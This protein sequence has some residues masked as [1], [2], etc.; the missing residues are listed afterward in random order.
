M[1][2]LVGVGASY[3]GP[4]KE[5]SDCVRDEIHWIRHKSVKI[6]I[7]IKEYGERTKTN[8]Q[9]YMDSTQKLIVIRITHS[10]CLGNCFTKLWIRCWQRKTPQCVNC[11]IIL[12][13]HHYINLGGKVQ[14]TF[15]DFGYFFYTFRHRPFPQHFPTLCWSCDILRLSKMLKNVASLGVPK[16]TLRHQ[17]VMTWNPRN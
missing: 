10:W 9:N 8:P 7:K 5:S 1:I 4:H 13:P 14:N 3:W 17:C 2:I 12:I 11:G 6:C 16:N 15:I